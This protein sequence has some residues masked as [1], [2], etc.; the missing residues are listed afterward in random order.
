MKARILIGS[1]AVAGLALGVG[2]MTAVAIPGDGGTDGG[3]GDS[4]AGTDVIVGSINGVSNYGKNTVNGVDIHGYAFGTTSCNIGTAVLRWYQNTSFHPVIPQNAF[5]IKNG[6]IEQI[7][8]G[9]MK[10]GFCALQENLCSTCQAGGVGCGSSQSSLGIGC[11]D[12][13][14]SSLNGSQ[15]GLGPRFEVNASTGYFPATGSTVWPT[16]PTGQGNINRR[17]QIKA[18]DLNPTLNVGAVYLAEACYVHPDDA[19]VNND[20]NNVSYVRVTVANNTNYSMALSGST[21]QQKAAI[22]HWAQVVPTVS[23]SVADST[24]GRFIIGNNVSQNADGSYHY[25]YA[26]Y[27]QNSDS[28][29]ASFSIPLAAG[30][31]ATNATFKDVAYHSGE[32]YDGTDWTVTNNG[33]ELKWQC[34]QTFAQNA[35]ANALRFG[36]LYNFSFDANSAGATG[37]AAFGLFKTATTLSVRAMVPTAVCRSGDLNCSGVID[38]ADLGALL[39]A[40]G[41]CAGGTPGCA[42]DLDNNGSVDG[43]DLGGLLAN[44]G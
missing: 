5:R 20:N 25:E 11:S 23:Y 44:W 41:P 3:T 28:S 13:Y 34:T 37:T 32:P 31:V 35:N 19:A 8:V 22:Y 17:V 14:S 38:G 12:P 24:D 2:Q 30:V 36:T 40:W 1:L 29:G 16:M 21:F 9:W 26:I 18:T 7:G 10:H 39:A 43:A 6:R 27:N 4:Q 33:T 42:G 15:S